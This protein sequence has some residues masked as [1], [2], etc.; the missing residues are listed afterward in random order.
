MVAA[1]SDGRTESSILDKFPLPYMTSL[2]CLPA[3]L[4]LLFPH[5]ELLARRGRHLI[6][7]LRRCGPAASDDQDA[8]A[9]A[10]SPV[11][12]SVDKPSLFAIAINFS[13]PSPPIVTTRADF[14]STDSSTTTH[15]SSYFFGWETRSASLGKKRSLARPSCLSWC[16]HGA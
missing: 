13:K 1:R 5:A 2:L 12:R 11:A 9:G 16:W 15:F 6:F 4:L 10:P 14:L 3:V 7:F 8:T